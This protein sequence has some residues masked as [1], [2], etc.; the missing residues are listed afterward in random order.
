MVPVD[1]G[2]RLAHKLRG[3]KQKPKTNKQTKRER[4]EHCSYFP[5]NVP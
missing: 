2:P 3:A 1:Y 4:L 5:P